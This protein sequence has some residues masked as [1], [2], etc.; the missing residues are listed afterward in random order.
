MTAVMG[1]SKILRDGSATFASRRRSTCWRS[2]RIRTAM[3]AGALKVAQPS[4]FRVPSS[5]WT[6]MLPADQHESAVES[7]IKSSSCKYCACSQCCCGQVASQSS[8]LVRAIKLLKSRSCYIVLFPATANKASEPTSKQKQCIDRNHRAL[9]HKQL[10][11]GHHVC[12]HKPATVKPANVEIDTPRMDEHPT[13]TN[14]AQGSAVDM[15][16]P[17]RSLTSLDVQACTIN[18]HEPKM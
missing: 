18:L 16:H 15:G 4:S 17:S 7:V 8:T 11:G 6:L 14:A 1:F 9:P 10:A 13:C 2:S 3:R 12:V 5:C